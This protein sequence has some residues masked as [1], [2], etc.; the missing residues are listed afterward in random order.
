M[1][2][3]CLDRGAARRRS[4]SGSAL[5]KDLLRRS[6]A[7]EICGLV[8]QAPRDALWRD[9]AK[10]VLGTAVSA[11][12][13]TAAKRDDFHIVHASVQG[14]HVHLIIEAQH[15][16]ALAKGMQGF[17][18]SAAKHLN[19][20]VPRRRGSVFSDRYHAP[21]VEHAARGP[22]L[23][24]VRAQQLA[25]SPRGSR[26]AVE[27]RS[28]LDGGRLLGLEGARRLAGAT[29]RDQHPRRAGLRA[30]RRLIVP[31]GRAVR[32]RCAEG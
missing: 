1:P 30:G 26:Q 11:C 28:V 3:S 22:Q 17:E 16:M 20:A 8:A 31:A 32:N 7:R 18:I 21:C 5:N 4:R 23:R 10:R 13:I 25:P 19:R 27:A 9:E 15:R 14:T 2:Q 24:R 12:A 6:S 29:R